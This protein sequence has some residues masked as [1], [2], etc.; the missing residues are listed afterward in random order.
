MPEADSQ[1]FA[2]YLEI[3]KKREL[4]IIDDVQGVKARLKSDDCA[5]GDI[6][7]VI[8]N[9]PVLC[10]YAHHEAAEK[11]KG[12]T[13]EVAGIDHALS[14]LGLQGCE[15]IFK[16]LTRLEEGTSREY[17]QLLA[18]SMMASIIAEVITRERGGNVHE[19][20]W[21]SLFARVAEWVLYWQQHRRCWQV[22]RMFYRKPFQQDK[23]TQSL[24]NFSYPEFQSAICEQLLLPAMNQRL[25][26]FSL[27]PVIREMMQVIHLY[28]EQDLRLEECSRELRMHLSAPEMTL[29]L[30]NKVA[31]AM[32]SPWLR[33]SWSNWFDLLAI[34]S[35]I[36]DH[37]L[38]KLLWDCCRKAE[39]MNVHVGEQGM[40]SA[41]F[42]ELSPSPYHLYMPSKDAAKKKAQAKL[43]QK[44]RA[45]EKP[46]QP[47]SK[48]K[49]TGSVS[50]VAPK[51]KKPKTQSASSSKEEVIH[52]Y[53][54]KQQAQVRK[55]T[56]KMLDAPG[57]FE[58]I[59][60]LVDEALSVCLNEMQFDRAVFC[61][62]SKDKESIKSLM[63]KQSSAQEKIPGFQV[64]LNQ[65]PLF[66]KFM[67]KQTFL[68]F[69]KQKH[70]KYW[71][72]LPKFIQED[73]RLKQFVFTSIS[74][75]GRVRSFLMADRVNSQHAFEPILLA[76]YKK[77]AGA[78]AS[79]LR[80]LSGH[81]R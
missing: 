21:A 62:L 12:R 34:H 13:G 66:N 70:A 57:S 39:R 73:E 4:P 22:R 23:V 33:N 77:F 18:E 76:D 75:N 68:Q 3:L 52:L 55:F 29:L 72:Q 38:K 45:A 36:K 28:R 2:Q 58:H 47:A 11:S 7:K 30:A 81:G 65:S 44:Q 9:D 40:V 26:D 48:K 54:P 74:Y 43:E 14:V 15:P 8:G 80:H 27:V 17:H 1:S 46:S 5:A 79:A 31:Q 10:L 64:V 50:V 32:C 41:L 61:G 78:L 71:S 49:P 6:A 59:K 20:A 56:N 19:L 69:D 24:F 16:S 63:S 51:P 67:Q 60:K 42:C 53:E 25:A 35:H 37:Q